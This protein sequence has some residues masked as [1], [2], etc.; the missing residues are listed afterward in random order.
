MWNAGEFTVSTGLYWIS[1]RKFLGKY[2]YY[3]ASLCYC[4][5]SGFVDKEQR[6]KSL[7]LQASYSPQNVH[8]KE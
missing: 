2:G 5:G 6:V 1:P 8:C 3:Q 4:L 7:R